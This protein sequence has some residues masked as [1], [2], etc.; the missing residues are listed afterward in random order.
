MTDKKKNGARNETVCTKATRQQQ[1]ALQRLARQ[2][3]QSVSQTL[4]DLMSR[5]LARVE[6][7]KPKN[8]QGTVPPG[9]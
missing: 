8:E 7:R 2:K 1:K 4:N 9:E 3:K 5:G 6:P